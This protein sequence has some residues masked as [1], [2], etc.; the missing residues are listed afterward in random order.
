MFLMQA[1]LK[2]VPGKAAM[3]NVSDTS[4]PSTSFNPACSRH[5]L[6]LVDAYQDRCIRAV[7]CVPAWPSASSMAGPPGVMSPS[8]AR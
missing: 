1:L 7:N 3:L 5:L 4:C 2:A 8:S 6:G